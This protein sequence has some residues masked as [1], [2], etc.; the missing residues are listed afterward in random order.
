MITKNT[1]DRLLIAGA[2]GYL[3]GYLVREAMARNQRFSAV[4]RH[5]EKLLQAGLAPEAIETRELTDPASVAGCCTGIDVVMSTVGITRQRDGLTY[6]DVDYQANRNLL[7]EALRAGVRKFIYVSAL[8]GDALRHL[9]IFEAKERFVDELRASGID[10]TVVRPNGFFS[11]MS[12]FVKM[13]ERGRVYLFGDGS[14]RL[15]PI[16]G[17]DLANVCLDAIQREVTEIEVGGPDVLS[18]EEI[19]RLALKACG[20]PSRVTHLPDWVRRLV[21]GLVR[22][23][24][25]VRIH[26][27]VEFFLTVMGS[28]YVAP[29]SGERRLAGFF[30]SLMQS[31]ASLS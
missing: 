30:D 1:N 6:M 20:K 24:T 12:D 9:K 23:V 11:D 14:Q 15:N 19:A 31:G 13:A 27:P 3:G 22:S 18:Q 17:A 5:P 7:D 26:G 2:T 29:A 10:Y 4:A 25:P 21:I 16:H 28:D 8:R